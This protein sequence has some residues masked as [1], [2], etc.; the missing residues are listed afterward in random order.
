MGDFLPH[1]RADVLAP[2]AR[3]LER[4]DGDADLDA[5][6]PFALVTA[7]IQSD[8]GYARGAWKLGGEYVVYERPMIV[9]PDFSNYVVDR[10]LTEDGEEL[11]R[12][13][14]KGFRLE[15]DGDTSITLVLRERDDSEL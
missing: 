8:A 15:A 5:S 11:P 6:G 3:E 14:R 7:A 13:G 10:V 2:V 12:E 1:R 9:Q 4:A